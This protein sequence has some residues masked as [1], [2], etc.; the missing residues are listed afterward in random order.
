[1]PDPST[2]NVIEKSIVEKVR[3]LLA[4]ADSD[5]NSHEHER[6][7]AMQAAMDLLAKHNLSMTEITAQS[8]D[9]P[10][11]EVSV[12]FK[13]E[14]W[15]RRILS[16]ACK[17][18][19]TRYY[20]VGQ[21]NRYN[22]LDRN[23]VFVGTAENIAVTISV[24]TWLLKSVRLESN[25]MYQESFER[26]SFRLGAADRIFERACEIMLSEKDNG[27][28]GGTSLMVLRNQFEKANEMHMSAKNLKNFKP[29]TLYMDG[30]AFADGEAFG[31]QV[32]LSKHKLDK[33]LRLPK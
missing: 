27:S 24:A 11:E 28:T 30:N 19:Y 14:P 12:N 16:A 9:V 29:R 4:L 10:P 15:V 31:N 7:V 5:K 32:G 13:L 23:P 17:L 20:M 8:L 33:T 21:R 26:R 3:K 6:A 25:R 1:M 22:R 2:G 18:Y